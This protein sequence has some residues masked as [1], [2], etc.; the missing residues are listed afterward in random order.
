M[1]TVRSGVRSGTRDDRGGRAVWAVWAA[2]IAVYLLAVT[3]R[4]SLGA[5]GLDAADR[6]GIDP[7]TLSL[8]VFL[9]ITVYAA[10]QIPA[11][12]LVDRYGPR[13]MLLVGGLILGV[14]QGVLAFTGALP[15]ALG[16]RAL[17]GAGDAVVF[18]AAMVVVARWFPPRRVPVVTQVTTI[19]GQLGQVLSALPLLLLLHAAGW[20]AAFAAAAAASVLSAAVAGTVVRDGPRGWRAPPP[21]SARTMLRQVADVW[22]RPGTRLGFFGHLGTQFSMMTFALLWG[23]PYLVSAQGLD[24]LLAGSLMTLLVLAAVVVGPLVGV[25]T[26]RHPM[27]RSWI[28][29][30]VIALTA[31]TWT[32]VLVQ[33]GPAPLWLL[34]VLIVVLAIG[35]PASVVGFDI[36]RTTN[37]GSTLAVAQGMVNIA[38][39]SASVVVLMVMGWVLTALGG[40]TPEGFRVAWLVQYP[41]WAV[42]VVGILVT[43]RKARRVDAARGIAPRPLRDVVRRRP[44][45]PTCGRAAVGVPEQ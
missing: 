1:G 20:T 31:G 17:V 19:V 23:L 18:S 34:V 29:L 5:A 43:R 27:R 15:L 45:S 33:P 41:V 32:A 38:G 3:Q 2:A 4:T 11:G 26:A 30:S 42:A 37:P 6:F 25:L 9:Q 14:G 35:G 22:R 39:Y 8:F 28:L 44:A 16:A 10:G 24:P 13:R 36:A 12:M 21:V 7:G 40:F